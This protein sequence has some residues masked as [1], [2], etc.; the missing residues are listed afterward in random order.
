MFSL[1]CGDISLIFFNF[2]IVV[3]LACIIFVVVD[4]EEWFPKNVFRMLKRFTVASSHLSLHCLIVPLPIIT[5]NISEE[6]HQNGITM[7]VLLLIEDTSSPSPWRTQLRNVLL[8]MKTTNLKYLSNGSKDLWSQKMENILQGNWST[9]TRIG[10]IQI[11]ELSGLYMG[12]VCPHWGL[13]PSSAMIPHKGWTHEKKN[14][15]SF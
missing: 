10:R 5:K 14:C 6:N 11:L 15:C 12:L 7:L 1:D 2:V 3:V 8:R 9:L 4:K 13:L